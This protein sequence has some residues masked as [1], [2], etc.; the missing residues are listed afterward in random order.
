MPVNQVMEGPWMTL[1][2]LPPPVLIFCHPLGGDNMSHDGPQKTRE[3]WII[4]KYD[5]IS[6]RLAPERLSCIVWGVI[7]SS[8]TVQLKKCRHT[9]SSNHYHPLWNGPLGSWHSEPCIAWPAGSSSGTA[10]WVGHSEP[11]AIPPGYLQCHQIIALSVRSSSLG[12]GRSQSF[13]L[14]DG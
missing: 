6:H 11:D 10:L 14:R 2:Q 7:Q 9:L 3:K 1:W 12:T 8:W 5:Y 13:W 4:G